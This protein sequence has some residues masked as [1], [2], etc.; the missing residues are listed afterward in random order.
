MFRGGF[1][2]C[3][4]GCA[5]GNRGRQCSNEWINRAIFPSLPG[6]LHPDQEQ[7]GSDGITSR[8]PTIRELGGDRYVLAEGQS[9]ILTG[10][11]SQLHS[12]CYRGRRQRMRLSDCE[13]IC[14]EWRCG[15]RV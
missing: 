2:I 1:R 8:L 14:K 5:N 7:T 6:E 11:D 12:N 4:P 3:D 9:H 10:D 15:H 13:A